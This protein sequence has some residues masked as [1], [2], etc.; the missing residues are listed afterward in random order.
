MR[1]PEFGDWPFPEDMPWEKRKKIKAAC[2]YKIHQAL[3]K[4]AIKKPDPPCPVCLSKTGPMVSHHYDYRKPL[5]VFWCCK[6][7]HYKH[8]R[9]PNFCVFPAASETEELIKAANN[10]NADPK[11]RWEAFRPLFIY[12]WPVLSI[13][14]QAEKASRKAAW[15]EDEKLYREMEKAEGAWL[16]AI[17]KLPR[18]EEA[19]KKASDNMDR[20]FQKE[21]EK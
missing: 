10:E 15:A 5:E 7:C 11:L 12:P 16:A 2:Q 14:E 4:G 17:D 13:E 1:S 18:D 21:A 19:I 3:K 8:H 9:L 6:S 20:V